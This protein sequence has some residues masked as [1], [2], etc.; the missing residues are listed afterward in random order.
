MKSKFPFT[1]L[2][3]AGEIRMV[4]VS[5]KLPTERFAAASGFVRL[6]PS[7]VAQLSRL[8]KGDPFTTAKI[9]GIQ[10]AKK[11]SELVPLT[12]PVPITHCDLEFKTVRSGIRILARVK[13]KSETGVEMEALAAVSIAALT[14][15]DMIKAVERGAVIEKIQLEEKSG[16]KSG[17]FVRDR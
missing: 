4:D 11:V 17:R 9:A 3:P 12:H 10:A 7:T 5:S 1:H 15:Y 13:T 16:G 14:L 2:N 8:K 6:N